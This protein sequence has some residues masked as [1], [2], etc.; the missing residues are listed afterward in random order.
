MVCVVC[1][2][3]CI[4]YVYLNA[5]FGTKLYYESPCTTV[6]LLPERGKMIPGYGGAVLSY[7]HRWIQGDLLA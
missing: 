3:L 1:D 4:V 6:C 2:I 5:A 7:R